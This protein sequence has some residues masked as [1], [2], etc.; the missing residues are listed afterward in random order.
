MLGWRTIRMI[1]NSRFCRMFSNN[2]TRK[3]DGA[4]LEPLILENPFD[5]GILTTG[6]HPCLEDHAK[7]PI[8][9][10]FALCV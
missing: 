7:G 2:R 9:D 3:V 1:C 4:H 5:G 6:H 10:D 8:P